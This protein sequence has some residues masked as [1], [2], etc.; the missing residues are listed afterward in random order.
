M[1]EEPRHRLLERL[2]ARRER[3]AERGRAY[4]TGF[5]IAGF[6]VVVLGVVLLPLPGPGLLVIAL[7]L[8][9]LALEFDWAERMLERAVNR[10]DEGKDAVD[11]VSPLQKVLG[12]LLLALAGAA[13]IVAVLLWDFPV[14]PV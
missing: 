8:A 1:A 14:L 11:K 12:A 6:L 4:R 10:L 2:H 5:T 9:M 7:G 13:T 3:H